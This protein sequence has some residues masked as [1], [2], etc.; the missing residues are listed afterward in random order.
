MHPAVRSM[1]SMRARASV[2][3]ES[4]LVAKFVNAARAGSTKSTLTTDESLGLARK[5]LT[6]SGT[7][8]INRAKTLSL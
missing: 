7:S 4:G 2:A 5:E 8:C 6:S 1:V 3:V